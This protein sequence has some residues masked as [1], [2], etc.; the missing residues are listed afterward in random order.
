MRAGSKGRRV[1]NVWRVPILSDR[2][3][4]WANAEQITFD[5]AFIR[6]LDVSPDGDELLVDSDRGGNVDLHRFLRSMREIIQPTEG[7]A[8]A[9][10]H[11]LDRRSK[12]LSELNERHQN[13]VFAI[14]DSMRTELAAVL[15]DEQRVRLE[16]CLGRRGDWGREQFRC[17]FCILHGTLRYRRPLDRENAEFAFRR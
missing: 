5:Q 11:I 4:T 1:A 9:L 8:G 15:T 2:E 16:A 12:Q 3:A 10:D 6:A 13:E 7:Q 17:G 14:M